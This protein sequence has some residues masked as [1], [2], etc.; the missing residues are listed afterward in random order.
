M[1]GGISLY[2]TGVTIL[3]SIVELV[4]PPIST[5]ANGEISGF[6][7]KASGISPQIAVIEVS[8]TGKN[9]VSP[10][11]ATAWSILLPSCRN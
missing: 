8:T 5:I 4:S 9:R 10:A 3:E 11:M 1:F 7:F 2:I 6:G